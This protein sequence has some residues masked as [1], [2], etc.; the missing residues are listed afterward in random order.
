[1]P[2]GVTRT[3]SPTR[4]ETLPEV[5]TTRPSATVRRAVATS[6][7]QASAQTDRIRATSGGA[8]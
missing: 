8:L 3:V 5:P 1:M 7:L 4:T 6:S 2:L